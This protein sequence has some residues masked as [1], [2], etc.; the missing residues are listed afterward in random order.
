MGIYIVCVLTLLFFSLLNKKPENNISG[1]HL[2]STFL[3]IISLLAFVTYS[4]YIVKILIV[5]GNM[6]VNYLYNSKL[7]FLII[8][9]ISI[10]ETLSIIYKVPFI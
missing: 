7:K 8:K 3:G 6:T 9:F 4:Y 5:R 10:I 2:A 1:F